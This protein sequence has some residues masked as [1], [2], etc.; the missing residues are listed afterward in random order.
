MENVQNT[1]FINFGT[2]NL[3]NYNL[4]DLNAVRINIAGNAN[5]LHMSCEWIHKSLLKDSDGQMARMSSRDDLLCNSI[6]LVSFIFYLLF[7]IPHSSSTFWFVGPCSAN[8]TTFRG[9]SCI[10]K[11]VTED[12]GLRGCRRVLIIDHF[13]CAALYE[14]ELSSRCTSFLFRRVSCH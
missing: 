4:N 7:F 2:Y 10:K 1:S 14:L 5:F 8:L 6:A 13:Q 12:C 11:A 9:H 3:Q